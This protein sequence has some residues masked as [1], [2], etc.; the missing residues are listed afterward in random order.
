MHRMF[1]FI[2]FA[3]F[4]NNMLIHLFIYLFRTLLF[5]TKTIYLEFIYSVPKR[6]LKLNTL[7]PFKLNPTFFE[8]FAE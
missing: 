8:L 5:R 6:Y 1:L 4:R 2:C 7:S 3:V